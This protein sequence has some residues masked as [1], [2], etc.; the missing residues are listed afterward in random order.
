[1]SE[2]R[3]AADVAKFYIEGVSRKGV[4][5]SFVLPSEATLTR[6]LETAFHASCMQEEGRNI[7]FRLAFVSE[8]N[9]SKSSIVFGS[10]KL[11]RF[12]IPRECSIQEIRRL[13]PSANPDR[14][15]ICIAETSDRKLE[16]IGLLPGVADYNPLK[17][18]A[19]VPRTGTLPDLVNILSED[20][21]K[22][23]LFAGEDCIVSWINGT[24]SPAINIFA[25]YTEYLKNPVIKKLTSTS[26]EIIEEVMD[27]LPVKGIKGIT[28]KLNSMTVSMYFRF[29][30]RIL[31]SMR[32]LHHG[33]AILI[34][35]DKHPIPQDLSIKY[36]M[37]NSYD[38]WH[39]IIEWVRDFRLDLK[40]KIA[41]RQQMSIYQNINYYADFI[42]NLSAVDGAV[43][44][45]DKFR[46]I[47]FGCEI[48]IQNSALE[49]V[50]LYVKGEQTKSYIEQV[51]T[52]HR[53]AYRFCN[54]Y[55]ESIAC[56]LS[57]DGSLKVATKD[58]GKVTALE[59]FV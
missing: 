27:E 29:L 37:D 30:Q 38:V 24:I 56:I 8:H 43:L 33:G 59:L 28:E 13:A 46:L 42:A 58:R 45:T 4:R 14:T 23:S 44:L 51:G 48:K 25:D 15:L 26:A 52:R 18:G 35:P 36:Q 55:P 39:S 49:S 3:S 6:M 7:N 9:L 32:N 1:M 34:I 17:T 11:I 10:D 21:G 47:G 2:F 41:G 5:K 20:P 31:Y 53:S 16:I 40:N 50:D 19:G 22:I 57:Q 12:T 54:E